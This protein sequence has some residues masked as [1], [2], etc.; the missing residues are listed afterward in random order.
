MVGTVP[1]S[2]QCIQ[3]I[4]VNERMTLLVVPL[5]FIAPTYVQLG[6]QLSGALT[7]RGTTV[8][9]NIKLF[10]SLAQGA[11]L[12]SGNLIYLHIDLYIHPSIHLSIYLSIHPSIYPCLSIYLSIYA[13]ARH[14]TVRMAQRAGCPIN[15]W[16][17]VNSCRPC[18]D[19]G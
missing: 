1:P 3:W 15:W 7:W 9:T 14:D 12:W 2:R 10:S 8:F 5:F 19:R 17:G 6:I 18:K 13:Y 11:T 4:R 16:K